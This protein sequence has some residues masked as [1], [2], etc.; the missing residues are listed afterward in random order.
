[1]ASIDHLP[2]QRFCG[3]PV[4]DRVARTPVWQPDTLEVLQGLSRIEEI[5][6]FR[7]SIYVAEQH[8]PL[9]AADHQAKRLPDADDH[10]AFHFCVRNSAKE[11]VGYTRM[12]YAEAI[13]SAE[14]AQLELGDLVRHS[15]KVLGFISKLMV[16]KSLRGRTNAVRLIM[17]MIE[18]G[19]ERFKEAE[20]AVFHCSSELVPLY[21]RMGFRPFGEPFLDPYVGQQTPMVAIFRDLEHFEQCSSPIAAIVATLPSLDEQRASSFREYFVVKRAFDG[22]SPVTA[23]T[24]AL[25]SLRKAI[26]VP[27][28]VPVPNFSGPRAGI[29]LA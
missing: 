28:P 9:P 17:T 27:V 29:K 4:A 12:H 8:K 11:L 16:D 21:R 15:P 25:A 24:P 22:D 13:P 26:H 3:R 1:M 14:I 18:Y 6:R 19:C 2:S 7:Y 5:E 23:H 10:S 20:G